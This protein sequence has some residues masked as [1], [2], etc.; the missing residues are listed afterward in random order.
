MKKSVLGTY[1]LQIL[2]IFF[3]FFMSIMI[4][5]ILGASERGE[6][7]IFLTST[8]FMS[9]LM[10]FCLSS[11]IIYYVASDK[12]Q[13]APIFTTLIYWTL[14]AL[15]ASTFVIILSPVF[16]FQQ[17]LFGQATPETSLKISF[18]IVAAL[19]VFNSLLNAVFLAK[20]LFKLSN[21]LTLGSVILTS[22]AYVVL[23]TL[24]NYEGY[25]FTAQ[26]F[27]LTTMII[28]LIKTTGQLVLY[29]KFISIPPSEKPLTRSSL[30]LLFS[31]STINYISNTVQFLSYRMDFWFV[32]YYS[33]SKELGIYSL[34]VNLAQLFWMLPNSVGAVLFPN[35]ASMDPKKAL[36]YTQMLCRIIFTSTI[37][38]G[39]AGGTILGY[40]IPFIYGVEFSSAS[41]LFYIL[42]IGIMPFSI[43]I[44]IASYYS[45]INKT[46]LDMMGSLI[47]FVFC[48]ISDI[49]LIPSYGSTGASIATVI[50]Y[51]SNTLFIIISFK[52]MTNSSLTSFLLIKKSDIQLIIKHFTIK[53]IP[54]KNKILEN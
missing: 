25:H 15:V 21:F 39:V 2:N 24:H 54:V 1:G 43:K 22:F 7:V 40:L 6:L 5:R 14:I 4:A 26:T 20:K 51:F 35:I 10:E 18:I 41:K 29:A 37:L 32:N 38:L 45:G 27:V 36:E 8:N 17:L 46:R 47:G 12:I 28:L 33:G 34:A 49:L 11:A 44:I 3:G 19:G 31:L 23:W 42:L 52:L 30:R 50:A 48:L 9:T 16:H 53:L 13:I